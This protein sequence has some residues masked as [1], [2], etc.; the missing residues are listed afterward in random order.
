MWVIIIIEFCRKQ[1]AEGYDINIQSLK[2][3][4]YISL[5]VIGQETLTD[6]KASLLP[7]SSGDEVIAHPI[8]MLGG[9]NEV[10][11]V[12]CLAWRSISPQIAVILLVLLL[13][14]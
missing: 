3:K 11:R 4:K 9:L 8:G 13:L 2:L 7:L 12:E 6:S 1:Q 14:F 10:L 5:S